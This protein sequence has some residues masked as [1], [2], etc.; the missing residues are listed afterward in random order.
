V[1]VRPAWQHYCC[2][3]VPSGDAMHACMHLVESTHHLA[4]TSSTSLA[5]P[6]PGG[7]VTS[8]S[9]RRCSASKYRAAAAA[10][11]RPPDRSPRH[12]TRSTFSIGGK[13]ENAI[14]K[15]PDANRSYYPTHAS[16]I[17]ASAAHPKKKRGSSRDRATSPSPSSLRV[18]RVA[19]ATVVA[20][21]HGGR[22]APRR[23][24]QQR[25]W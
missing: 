5:M 17:P 22:P 3:T 8:P 19:A 12:L 14:T 23:G 1:L 21:R 10:P 7:P 15:R 20:R 9:R 6:P 11:G 24:Q 2:S 18:E 4:L 16:S 13:R 25:R